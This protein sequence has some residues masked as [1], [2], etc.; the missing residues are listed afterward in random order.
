[1]T[2]LH[3]LADVLRAVGVSVVEVEGWKDRGRGGDGG[4]YLAN[5]P[6]HIML[7]HTAGSAGA[8]AASEV[9]YMV[10]VAE[11]APIANIY[12]SRDEGKGSQAY[13][14]AA[15]PT[16]TNGSG[17]APWSRGRVADSDMNRHAIGIEIGNSGVGEPYSVSQQNCVVAVVTALMDAYGIELGS[18]R[19]HAEWSPSRKI[20]PA[21]PSAW[22]EWGGT[23]NMDAF[24]ADILH[25]YAGTDEPTPPPP[26]ECVTAAPGDGGW[27]LMRKLGMD[28][29]DAAQ[30]VAFYDKNYVVYPDVTVCRP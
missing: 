24:R 19:S 4:Q 26:S 29:T 11:Y 10:N 9:N 17:S 8:S 6:D 18:V 23:W 27:S 3:N 12:I 22:A 25:S 20:D 7:H 30:R 5:R 15:G 21:G 14:M 1:M 13:V 28:P 2:R 16:N